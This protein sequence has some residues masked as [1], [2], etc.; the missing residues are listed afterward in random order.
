MTAIGW[1]IEDAVDAIADVLLSPEFNDN[2]AKQYEQRRRQMPVR[3]LEV[4]YVG[5]KA[6]PDG[7][8]CAEV[9]V[10]DGD[11][12]SDDPMIPNEISLQFTVNGT[13]EELMEREILRLI[14]AAR[15]TFEGQLLQPF[16]GGS[17]VSTRR[18]EYSPT[19]PRRTTTQQSDFVKSGSLQLFVVTPYIRSMM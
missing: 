10:I 7:Y 1:D 11:K 14:G 16:T 9:I 6:S 12:S 3:F 5:E 4:V 8:P 15:A 19:V 2:L 13:S 18:A 17:P